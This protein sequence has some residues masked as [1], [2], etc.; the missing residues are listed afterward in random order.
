MRKL[1]LTLPLLLV[2]LVPTL[3]AYAWATPPYATVQVADLNDGI[4]WTII[5]SSIDFDYAVDSNLDGEVD[6]FGFWAPVMSHDGAY[7]GDAYVTVDFIWGYIYVELW[8]YMDGT[9]VYKE[10]YLD[11]LYLL[12][13]GDGMYSFLGY[14]Q[15][16]IF[17]PA[18]VASGFA[19]VP[20]EVG[21]FGRF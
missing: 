6:T 14:Y 8:V 2:I 21:G 15:G 7:Y 4:F 11:I 16:D 3:N 20:F 19:Y 1:L 17:T 5:G 12:P 9:W 13:L 10:Y 18:A